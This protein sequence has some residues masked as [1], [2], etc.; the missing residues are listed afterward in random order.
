MPLM[1][2]SVPEVVSVIAPRVILGV[3]LA[4]YFLTYEGLGGVMALNRVGGDREF[5]WAI[6]LLVGVI[7][8]IFYSLQ[9]FTH[10]VA[11]ERI[12]KPISVK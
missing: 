9:R 12:V 10:S 8:I 11:L 2:A 6:I 4:E 5:W 7:S 1:L 3:M